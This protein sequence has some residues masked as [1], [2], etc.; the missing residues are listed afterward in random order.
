MTTPA[1]AQQLSNGNAINTIVQ[2]YQDAASNW[3]QT[4]LRE[5]KYVFYVLAGISLAWTAGQM[6]MRRADFM[7]I[8]A[9]IA[10]F[11]IVT[12]FFYWI[13]IAGSAWAQDIIRSLQDLGNKAADTEGLSPTGIINLGFQVFTNA[14]NQLINL[15]LPG[16]GVG[17]VLIAALILLCCAMIGIN[18]VVLL[19]SSWVVMYAGI[20]ILGFGGCRWTS[21]MA[22]NYYRAVL[23]IGLKLM[24]MTLIIGIGVNFLQSEVNSLNT[25]N[26]ANLAV[27]AVSALVLLMLSHHLPN[28]V[29]NI[30]F[31]GASH[32]TVGNTSGIAMLVIGQQVG[33]AVSR[34]ITGA[35][36]G[37]A[38]EATG[39]GA[40]A[41]DALTRAVQHGQQASTET[42]ANGSGGTGK[43]GLLQSLEGSLGSRP[44][45][46]GGPRWPALPKQNTPNLAISGPQASAETPPKNPQTVD[47]SR[48]FVREPTSA[49]DEIKA[50]NEAGGYYGSGFP[51]ESIDTTNQDT[52]AT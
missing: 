35:M 40:A 48:G 16:V 51:D 6:A 37:G 42:V 5:A 23:A 50:Y 24:V 43:A 36:T 7:E 15:I 46:S 2:K 33:M 1:E 41:A 14:T 10:R 52:E 31:G 12:S 28:I 8:V 3:A 11:V 13:M 32:A 27:I 17:V 47:E 20:I 44:N 4:I 38:T 9:E 29:S 26:L 19:C 21:E 39:G 22:I 25:W 45:A 30:V 49:E 18:M 34:A